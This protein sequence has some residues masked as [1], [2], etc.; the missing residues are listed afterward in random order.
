MLKSIV[1]EATIM[2]AKFKIGDT[3]RITQMCGIG[4]YPDGLVGKITK[5]PFPGMFFG[6]WGDMPLFEAFDKFEKVELND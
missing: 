3:V 6:T 5:H 2:K 1:K 4:K